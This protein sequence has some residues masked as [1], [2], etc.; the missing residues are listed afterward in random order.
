MQYLLPAGT[1]ETL[2]ARVSQ[3]VDIDWGTA[4][5]HISDIMANPV[6]LRLLNDLS[7]LCVS[8]DFLPGKQYRRVST[9][10]RYHNQPANSSFAQG[11]S[12]MDKS[13]DSTRMIPRIILCMGA[14][15]VEAV[16]TFNDA[17]HALDSY[18]YIVVRD[19][20]EAKKAS[21][22]RR[23]TNCVAFPWVKEC[24]IAG[25]LLPRD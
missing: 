3:M 1:S 8:P 22:A 10:H 15:R 4:P 5:E 20:E 25:R 14:S 23:I 18:D 16:A 12:D 21:K 11:N 19:A 6:P 24:L 2:N 9:P 7:V 13:R 17:S